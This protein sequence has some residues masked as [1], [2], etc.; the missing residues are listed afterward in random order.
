MGDWNS[1]ITDERV[2]FDNIRVIYHN[3][4]KNNCKCAKKTKQ[5]SFKYLIFCEKYITIYL[6]CF[7][8]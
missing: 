1:K 2:I 4:A 3:R 7:L 8:L 5:I 6:G